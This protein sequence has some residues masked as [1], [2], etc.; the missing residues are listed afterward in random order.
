MLNRSALADAVNLCDTP[1]YQHHTDT[2][3]YQHHTRYT[4]PK[5]LWDTRKRHIDSDGLARIIE[6][7]RIREQRQ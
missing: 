6:S 5:F 3:F 4:R 7:C 2:P 1:F